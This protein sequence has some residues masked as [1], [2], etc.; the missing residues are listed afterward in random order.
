MPAL[1]AAATATVA[2]A[3][4]SGTGTALLVTADDLLLEE[5]LR[6]AAAAGVVL[7]VAHDAGAALRGWSSASLVLVG[8]DQ[9]AAL[10]DRRPVR[11]AQVH[12]V[13]NGALPDGLFRA[14][15]EIGA[16]DVV[17]LPAAETWLVELLTDTADGAAA[18]ATT[19]GVVAGSGGAGATTFAAAL[20]TVAAASGEATLVDVD[21]LGG[22]IDRVVGMDA[23]EGIRWDALVQAQGRFSSR[24]LRE[25]LPRRD[26]LAV[27]TWSQAP[28]PL[29][30]VA[31]REVLSAAQRGSDLVV[32]DLP[33]HLDPVTEDVITRCDHVVVV[34][35]LTV[36]AVAAAGRVVGALQDTA[37]RLHLVTRGSTPGLEPEQV[38]T[39]LSVPLLAT[40]GRQRRLA[41]T[42]DLGLGPVHSP[43]SPLARS[44]RTVL[45]AT[46]G[47]AGRRVATARRRA[48]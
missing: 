40:V 15:L 36:P 3:A 38:S 13:S 28:S 39:A 26:A 31:V 5:L 48:A 35:G 34:A 12:V 11:R 32:V 24:S 18:N 33:R 47:P 46:T 16:Q 37:R 29:D 2:P 8:A 7:D 21:P 27:L 14:A 17:E 41:E 19:L 20:A 1:P 22:G 10:A 44:A 42:I 30:P 6:L 43:R 4:G 23:S 45:A 25:A 9:V